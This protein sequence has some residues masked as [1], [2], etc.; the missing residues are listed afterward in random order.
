MRR[1]NLQANDLLDIVDFIKNEEKYTARINELREQEE[2]LDK[3]LEIVETLE[4]AQA[5]EQK[6][7][8]LQ[9]ILKQE[10]EALKE[11]YKTLTET[12]KKEHQDRLNVIA[13]RESDLRQVR[14]QIGEEREE[15][16]RISERQMSQKTEFT[17]RESY[18]TSRENKLN[19]DET[20]W[21]NKVN[22]LNQILGI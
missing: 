3:K 17:K 14:H 11:E 19:A 12:L 22:Q 13:Q 21:R 15:L 2:R 4:A 7:I 16:R 18:L 10:R 8:D 1:A 9:L 20:K 6:Y 5:L